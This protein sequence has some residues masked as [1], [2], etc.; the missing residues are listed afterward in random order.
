MPIET[1]CR[2]SAAAAAACLLLVACGRGEREEA[3]VR[4]DTANAQWEDGLSSQQVESEARALSPEEAE[5]AGLTVDTT[6]HLEVPTE[7]DTLY[8]PR[9]NEPTPPPVDPTGRDTLRRP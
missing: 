5:A 1:L 9:S 7:Q 8:L 2:R 3:A 6:I 4:M